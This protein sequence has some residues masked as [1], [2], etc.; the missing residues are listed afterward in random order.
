MLQRGG[1]P[2]HHE[3]RLPAEDIGDGG[4][5][6]AI[7]RMRCL[8]ILG[9]LELFNQQMSERALAR[10]AETQR[11]FL[12]QRDEVLEVGRGNAG[13]HYQHIRRARNHRNRGEILHRAVRNVPHRGIGAVRGNIAE[14]QGVAIGR[15]AHR[16]L[17]SNHATAT[18]HVFNNKCLAQ[19]ALQSLRHGARHHV[20][21]AAGS[22]GRDDFDSAVG[23]GA[24]LRERVSGDHANERRQRRC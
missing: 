12:C 6:A 8:K 21:A 11:R 7:R 22:D 4:C 13:S 23:I 14:H 20:D 5:D 24:G 2:R 1:E 16:G 9:H 18:A 17:G 15:G 19:R 3:L 10:A